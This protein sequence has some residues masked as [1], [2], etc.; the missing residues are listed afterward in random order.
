MNIRSSWVGLNSAPH[1]RQRTT[2]GLSSME[3]A[4]PA[5]GVLMVKISKAVSNASGTMAEI[6]P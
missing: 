4:A 5:K 1:C 6:C 3:K 2:M